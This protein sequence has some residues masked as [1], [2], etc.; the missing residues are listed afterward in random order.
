MSV[1]VL[2]LLCA[3]VVAANASQCCS[4]GLNVG[5]ST[6]DPRDAPAGRHKYMVRCEDKDGCRRVLASLRAHFE[7]GGRDVAGVREMRAF[8]D[9]FTARL[10]ATALRWLCET[11]ELDK[12]ISFVEAD[13]EV[14]V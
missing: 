11:H 14:S 2:A 10:S 3:L 4:W 5:S 13:Q 12:Y 7:E 8:G 1:R 6:I 9:I